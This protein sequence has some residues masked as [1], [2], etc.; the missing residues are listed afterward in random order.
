MVRL[1]LVVAL[2]VNALAT[3]PRATS[4]AHPHADRQAAARRLV[5][6]AAGDLAR[7]EAD[8]ARRA[9]SCA[10]ASSAPGRDLSLE[11]SDDAFAALAATD[12]SARAWPVRALGPRALGSVALVGGGAVAGALGVTGKGVRVAIIDTGVDYLHPALG[13]SGDGYDDQD[14]ARIDDEGASSALFPTARVVDGWDFAGADGLHPDA[15]PFP[16]GDAAALGDP[17]SQSTTARR[18]PAW[19]TRWR[20]AT[21]VAYKVM[22]AGG[23]A[24]PAPSDLVLAALEKAAEEKRTRRRAA[25]A[26]RRDALALADDDPLVVAI[27]ALVARGVTVSAR[28]GTAAAPPSS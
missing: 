19:C 14:P 18:W 2:A 4:P 20:R 23:A 26:R 3:A 12:P 25:R 9:W 1:A 24:A 8:A 16:D 15:D 21:L 17:E 13:G 5:H 27:D 6:T 22:A 10:R 7:L 28:P 11:G